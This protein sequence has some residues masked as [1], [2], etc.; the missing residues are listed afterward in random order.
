[1]NA[2]GSLAT[3]AMVVLRHVRVRRAGRRGGRVGRSARGVPST[4]PSTRSIV[5]HRAPANQRDDG[6]RSCRRCPGAARRRMRTSRRRRRGCRRSRRARLGARRRGTS[7]TPS[8]AGLAVRARGSGR[9]AQGGQQGRGARSER[10]RERGVA[11]RRRRP[12][13]AN[14][15]DAREAGIG[16]GVRARDSQR[17]TH[18]ERQPPGSG[19]ARVR[20]RGTRRSTARRRSSSRVHLDFARS[21]LRGRP[22]VPRG[23]VLRDFAVRAQGVSLRERPGADRGCGSVE[24]DLRRDRDAARAAGRSAR[25]EPQLRSGSILG[26]LASWRVLLDRYFAARPSPFFALGTHLLGGTQSEA[27]P[28]ARAALAR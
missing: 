18:D 2:R 25:V 15:G 11:R 4:S 5:V 3:I 7:R 23:V 16:S 6:G 22:L 21:V 14:R 17:A 10:R 9:S 13:A 19:A 12:A 24:G 26:V 8:G 28:R 20:R 1:M 27:L